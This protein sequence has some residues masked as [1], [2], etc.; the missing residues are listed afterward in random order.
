MMRDEGRDL[1]GE[2][3][4]L[5]PT[6][7]RPIGV[8]RWSAR[9]V[10]L[11]LLVLL[12]LIPAAVPM[13]WV[14][15]RSSGNP[16]VG[17]AVSGGNG[18]CTQLEELWLQAQAVPSASFIPCVQAF[19]AGIHGAL[20]VRNGESVLQFDRA[21]V[22][23]KL[24]IAEWPQVTATAGSVTVRLTATCAVQT[25]QAGQTIAPGV[26]RF[27]L[28][29]PRR[30]SEVVD[31]F[32]GGCVTYRPEADDG[33][34]AAL[35]DQA[36]RAVSL[37]TRDDLRQA[38]GAAP[39]AGLTLTPQQ[40]ESGTAAE[41]RPS[42]SHQ[43]NATGSRKA[44]SPGSSST[45][46]TSSTFSPSIASIATTGTAIPPYDPKLLLGVLLYAYCIGA[47]SSRQIEQ[48]GA[49]AAGKAVTT[50]EQVI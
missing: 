26:R 2:F 4:R 27:Q 1:H 14:F 11:L 39:A 18:S 22:D 28:E 32:P 46:S 35:L 38:L 6:P 19:P 45:S 15:A 44:T 31:V 10:G 12:V 9:R 50:L 3:V 21:S 7:P 42:C 43:T 33:A 25:T 30:T 40:R 47:R 24:N 34:S 16:S 17:A 29:G 5:L 8:Q 13:A 41:T 23:I 37:R 36:Q 48:A 49:A 20:R